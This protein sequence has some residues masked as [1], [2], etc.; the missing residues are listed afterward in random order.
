MK[1]V[2]SNPYHYALSAQS[3]RNAIPGPQS[4]QAKLLCF[5]LNEDPSKPS[6]PDKQ[7]EKLKS[8]PPKALEAKLEAW[9][10]AQ[11]LSVPVL[12]E[13]AKARQNSQIQG[14]PTIVSQPTITHS[15]N[16][17]IQMTHLETSY[18]QEEG[19]RLDSSESRSG[20]HA[21]LLGNQVPGLDLSQRRMECAEQ[22][23]VPLL[24]TQALPWKKPVIVQDHDG[25]K[26]VIDQH[27]L[28]LD[29]VTEQSQKLTIPGH[30]QKVTVYSLKA[31]CESPFKEYDHTWKDR[32]TPKNF[33]EAVITAMSAVSV[34]ALELPEFIVRTTLAAVLGV[35]QKDLPVSDIPRTAYRAGTD[36]VSDNPQEKNLQHHTKSLFNNIMK[37]LGA[38]ALVDE[39]INDMVQKCVDEVLK[40]CTLPDGTLDGKC[41]KEFVSES[42]WFKCLSPKRQK[43]LNPYID[44]A[45]YGFL[46]LVTVV[47]V[48]SI[49][50]LGKAK[51]PDLE[52]ILNASLGENH[53][54][55]KGAVEYVNIPSEE[56]GLFSRL[57][58]KAQG[59][60]EWVQARVQ[61]AAR[62]VEECTVGLPET[63]GDL[64]QDTDS[65]FQ[66]IY[67]RALRMGQ[68]SEGCKQECLTGVGSFIGFVSQFLPVSLDPLNGFQSQFTQL[69][70]YAESQGPL[71]MASVTNAL[72]NV[73]IHGSELAAKAAIN[74][75]GD[76]AASTIEKHSSNRSLLQYLSTRIFGN[77][78]QH[79]DSEALTNW[80][81][82]QIHFAGRVIETLQQIESELIPRQFGVD[83]KCTTSRL[84]SLSGEL[85]QVGFDSW[86]GKLSL[87]GDRLR[88][89]S[90]LVSFLASDYIAAAIAGASL[91]PVAVAAL[92]F[93][94]QKRS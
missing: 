9:H 40:K 70:N 19:R 88:S 14:F 1:K 20:L 81:R 54:L 42:S 18:L 80:G 55:I 5:I 86:V 57:A 87:I 77:A 47:E 89:M 90:G 3:V 53:P 24:P 49:A 8:M 31:E 16:S 68:P 30:P 11:Q 32:I 91:P 58:G 29:K 63:N 66:A 7:L 82:M 71:E 75:L 65:K 67:S 23:E 26:F 79:I 52:T 85:Q 13:F 76:Y 36:T 44:G 22:R 56:P 60:V 2:L 38:Y 34:A 48:A 94:A 46:V 61:D 35:P 39:S 43:E 17:Q 27:Y 72:K 51:K 21:Q 83:V 92:L 10:S 93:A 64:G 62:V 37:V 15:T 25:Q 50:G 33:G 78:G 74:A 12:Y 69:L 73:A 28:S 45:A 84:F 41:A 6:S 59:A 4:R